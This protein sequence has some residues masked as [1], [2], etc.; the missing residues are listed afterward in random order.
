MMWC[1]R[2]S[3]AVRKSLMCTWCRTHGDG[4]YINLRDAIAANAL[5]VR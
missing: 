2:P 1:H 3:G 4:V 5:E